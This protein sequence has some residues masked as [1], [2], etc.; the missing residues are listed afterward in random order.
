MQMKN[1]LKREKGSMAVYTIASILSFVIILTGIFFSASSVRKNQLRTLM[2]IK[3][4]YGKTVST[5]RDIY[6]EKTAVAESNAYI[7]DGLILHYDAINNTGAGHSNNTTTWKDLSGNGNDCQLSNFDVTTSSG[8]SKSA[9]N[10]D[11]VDD[12]GTVT[13]LQETLTG[14]VTISVRFYTENSNNYRGLYGN[15]GGTYGNVVG[16]VAQYENDQMHFG[17]NT[18]IL[19]LD[20]DKTT[21]QLITLTIQMDASIGTKVYINETLVGQVKN[22]ETA[23]IPLEP[24]WIGKSFDA[25][26]RYFAGQMNNFK[27]YNRILTEAEIKQN[28]EIDK[29]R[30]NFVDG[31]NL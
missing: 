15:H 26:D 28:Y 1:Y 16:I 8:W 2:K 18:N 31:T 4:V 20:A 29:E 19:M 24:F 25:A 9:L 5:R 17:Y 6:D 23:I 22:E 11:G 21:N 3:E 27:I 30:Y 13:N 14:P 12:F 10:F 7:K